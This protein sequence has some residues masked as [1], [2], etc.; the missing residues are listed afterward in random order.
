MSIYKTNDISDIIKFLK[1]LDIK[2]IISK[3]ISINLKFKGVDGGGLFSGT[4]V[5]DF[6]LQE[7]FFTSGLCEKYNYDCFDLKI[8]NKPLSFK[9]ISGKSDIALK[10]SKNKIKTNCT[11][12][13]ILI[14][15]TGNI[16]WW[17]RKK[18]FT[19]NIPKGFFIIPSFW[20][21]KNLLTKNNKSDFILD[22]EVLYSLIQKSIKYKFFVSVKETDIKVYNYKLLHSFTT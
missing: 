21:N 22:K 3:A 15:N 19:T 1:T 17:K 20:L 11:L 13:H 5:E 7:Y 12:S 8:N 14:L 6:V 10:W 4:L 9:K 2:D 18:D 16:S